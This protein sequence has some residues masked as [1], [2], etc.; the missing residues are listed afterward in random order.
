MEY[1]EWIRNQYDHGVT[2]EGIAQ[3]GLCGPNLFFEA[4]DRTAALLKRSRQQSGSI[5]YPLSEWG[6]TAAQVVAIIHSHP[7]GVF[8][9]ETHEVNKYPSDNRTVNGVSYEGGD[10]GVADLLRD[11]GMNT[12]DFRHYI[13]G[14]DGVTRE[15]DFYDRD[16]E[17]LGSTL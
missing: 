4:D 8:P 10:C 7:A 14:P 16:A 9:S 13:I 12:D 5:R 11:H 6:I 17:T 2:A 15:Y 3:A 1:G